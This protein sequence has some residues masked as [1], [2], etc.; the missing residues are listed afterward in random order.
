MSTGVRRDDMR[1]QTGTG[2][3][4]ARLGTGPRDQILPWVHRPLTEGS[5]IVRSVRV[6]SSERAV[7]NPE[8]TISCPNTYQRF[9]F[10][11]RFLYLVTPSTTVSSTTGDQEVRKT[12]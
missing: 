4:M 7:L 5:A 12:Q 2:P 6:P 8:L 3:A 10:T 1:T 9:T 11:V